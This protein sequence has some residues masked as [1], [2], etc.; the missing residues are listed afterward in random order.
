M[1]V[2]VA[3]NEHSRQVSHLRVSGHTSYISCYGK[4][5]IK[6]QLKLIILTKGEFLHRGTSIIK[7]LLVE[8]WLAG[9]VQISAHTNLHFC[10]PMQ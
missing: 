6:V 8:T 7:K 5:H 10:L 3:D 1:S 9:I 2:Q 4:N